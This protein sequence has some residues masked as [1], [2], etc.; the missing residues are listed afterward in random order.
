MIEK[1]F[2]YIELFITLCGYDGTDGSSLFGA[3]V[4]IISSMI[5]LY[6]FYF[7]ASRTI[8]PKSTDGYPIKYSI[9][10]DMP[11]EVDAD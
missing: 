7:A 4:V 11:G 9:L 10:E 8:W 1:L 5:V 3:V 2:Y 6:S